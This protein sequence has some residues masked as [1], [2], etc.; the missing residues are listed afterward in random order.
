MWKKFQIWEAQVSSKMILMVG[1]HQLPP[2]SSF[3]ELKDGCYG[4]DHYCSLD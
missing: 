2:L 3:E 4:K 1:N